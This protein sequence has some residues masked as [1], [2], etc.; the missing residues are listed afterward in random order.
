MT[1]LGGLVLVVALLAAAC[2]AG[3]GTGTEPSAQEVA[4]TATVTAVTAE[5]EPTPPPEPTLAREESEATEGQAE[6][7][8]LRAETLEGVLDVVLATI[9][10]ERDLSEDDYTSFFDETFTQQ[11]PY[12][13][14]QGLN[15]Q[16]ADTAPWIV[17]EPLEQSRQSG[18]F[19]VEDKAGDRFTVT[20]ALADGQVSTLF[21]QP[22][23]EPP[24]GLGEALTLLDETG[25]FAYLVAEVTNDDEC[26]P[27]D[28]RDAERM[29]PLGSV[30]KLLVLGGV[31]DAVAGG[32][33]SWDDPVTIRDE[34]DSY[35][36]GVTQDVPAGE[37]LTVREL[38]VQMISIS[39]NTAT[40]HLLHLVGRETVE[41]AQSRW[42]LAD[43]EPN[44][45]FLSTKELFQ[46]KLTPELRDAYLGADVAGRRSMLADLAEVP[47]PPI[48][49]LGTSWFEPIEI[50]TL[51]WFATPRDICRI[52]GRLALDDQARSILESDPGPPSER[53]ARI[54]FKGGS[55]P[56]VLAAAWIVSDDDGRTFTVTGGVWNPEQAFDPTSVVAAFATLRDEFELTSSAD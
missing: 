14:F 4:P 36:S 49:E 38:A 16:L 18:A 35:P 47:L 3:D 54:G 37:T 50:D 40:D 26:R 23:V 53:W 20:I 9:N 24:S 27:V 5:P 28:E 33:L 52:L 32:E 8:T 55:E 48:D 41:A 29:M 7:A 56:G 44:V 43:S 1:R 12:G 17:I 21:L 46:I 22:F 13:A 39:D 6:P 10:G 15:A 51:E 2:T 31:V 34:L 30:F 19:L 11:V 42:G 25:E 45:P